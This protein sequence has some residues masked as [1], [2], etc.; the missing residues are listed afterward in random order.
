MGSP[1]HRQSGPRNA[2]CLPAR[3]PRASSKPRSTSAPEPWVNGSNRCISFQQE[4][5][6]DAKNGCSRGKQQMQFCTNREWC[7]ESLV[8]LDTLRRAGRT[9]TLTGQ[10][11]HTSGIASR[12]TTGATN[13]GKEL[14]QAANQ[15]TIKHTIRT[16]DS[17]TFGTAIAMVSMPPAA[18]SLAVLK[19]RS[20]AGSRA[21]ACPA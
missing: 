9:E 13:R 4:S 16:S 17:S 18:R 11:S 20:G 15:H 7:P 6:I 19:R 8:V 12:R 2:V 14:R 1:T 5:T 10:A 3:S 21:G